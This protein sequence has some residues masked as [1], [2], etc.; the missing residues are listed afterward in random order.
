MAIYKPFLW[1][2]I[3]LVMFIIWMGSGSSSS[4]SSEVIEQISSRASQPNYVGT[5]RDP[6]WQAA[7]EKASAEYNQ[8]WL[9]DPFPDYVKRV[10]DTFPDQPGK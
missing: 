9:D 4:S 8:K 2:I 6:A 1:A 10:L 5:T 3:F 7:Y